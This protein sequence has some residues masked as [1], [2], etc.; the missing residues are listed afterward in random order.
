MRIILIILVFG[1]A[2][3]SG[4]SDMTL[5]ERGFWS[6][7]PARTWEESLVTGNGTQGALV[8]GHPLTDTIILSHAKFYMPLH[9]P[10]P[11]VNSGAKLDSIRLMMAAGEFGKA[12]Q[13]VVDLSHREGWGGKRWTD[14]FVPAFDIRI[15]TETDTACKDYRRMVNFETGEA[16]VTWTNSIGKF[17]RKIFA[18]RADTLVAILIQGPGRGKLNCTISLGD[19]P[20]ENS[21]WQ[22]LY[23]KNKRVTQ[24]TAE[25]GILKY[26]TRFENTWP[27][28][29]SGLDGEVRVINRHGTITPSNNEMVIQHADE[30]LILCKYSPTTPTTPTTTITTTT[31]T[32]TSSYSSL[33]SRHLPLHRDLFIR[34]RLDLQGGSDRELSS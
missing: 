3:C 23:D 6:E 30:I 18:T 29:I 22:G 1:I 15:K 8:M 24:I 34:T 9:E 28:L 26:R 25:N 16:T 17:T 27:G 21:W 2:G 12:S 14:P 13:Y 11:P 19:R 5:P 7:R 33:L 20:R 10:L 31:T 4:N 32:T